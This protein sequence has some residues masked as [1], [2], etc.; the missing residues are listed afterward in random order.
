MTITKKDINAVL[1][2]LTEAFPQAFVLDQ[3]QPRHRPLK[4]GIVPE[5][6]A[7]CPDLARSDLVTALNIYTRRIV[8]LQSL[9][10]GAARVDLDGNA[11]GEVSAADREHAVARL[12]EIQAMREAKRA[13][14]SAEVRK[15]AWTVRQEKAAARAAPVAKVSTLMEKPVLRLPASQG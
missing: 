7:R 1:T 13:G 5:I 11:Y 8:Y 2:R 14:A 9:V 6:A 15:P 3:Y 4:V 10:A 12:A